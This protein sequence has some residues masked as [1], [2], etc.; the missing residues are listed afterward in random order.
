MEFSVV[1]QIYLEFY[2]IKQTDMQKCDD[3]DSM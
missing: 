1:S 3:D 2:V